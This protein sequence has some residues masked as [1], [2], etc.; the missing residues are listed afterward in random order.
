MNI[1]AYLSYTPETAGAAGAGKT[2]T[3]SATLPKT[4]MF[5]LHW[6]GVQDRQEVGG[7]CGLKPTLKTGGS[8]LPRSM[9]RCYISFVPE[10]CCSGKK[11][12]APV[13]NPDS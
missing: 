2:E 1:A 7:L 8:R 12:C 9:S 5:C 13:T 6:S 3:G 11:R 4:K 10:P